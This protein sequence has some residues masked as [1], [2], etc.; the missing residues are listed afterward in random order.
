MT[1]KLEGDLL[2][3]DTRIALVV[4]RFNDF[5]TAK[6]VEGAVDAYTRHG[7]DAGTLTLAYTPGSFE[8]PITALKL[9][10][11]GKFQAVVCLGCIIRGQTDHYDHVASE[12]TKGIAYV[13]VQTGVPTIFGVITADN[14]EQ[15]ID[16][17]GAK[18]GNHGAKAM[19]T[20]IEM[21]NLLKKI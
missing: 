12:A 15:A 14:L 16:R 4:S 20:A 2:A 10:Q 5:L 6:L 8:M 1:I 7:G 21:V 13:G 19:M 3:R 18:Q 17:A 11:T 9:A